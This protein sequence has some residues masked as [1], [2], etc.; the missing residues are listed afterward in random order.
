[1]SCI[2]CKHAVPSD[3]PEKMETYYLYGDGYTDAD[4]FNAILQCTLYPIWTDVSGGHF[5]S[6]DTSVM[7]PAAH[8]AWAYRTNNA[9]KDAAEQRKR[10]IEAE[11]KL[12]AL[13]KKM[14][15]GK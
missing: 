9:W 7:D 12:K 8:N 13:R 11:K 1:M 4:R 15:D 6:N 5:C 2:R 10:A 3:W 14:K